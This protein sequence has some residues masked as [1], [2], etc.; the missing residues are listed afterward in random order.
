MPLDAYDFHVWKLDENVGS[1]SFACSGTVGTA[2]N[3]VT[4]SPVAGDMGPFN[5][6]LRHASG[7]A[8]R[9]TAAGTAENPST[10]ALSV[11]G[12]YYPRAAQNGSP[13]YGRLITKWHSTTF[14][15]GY[16]AFS[17]VLNISG[18]A[19]YVQGH[20]GAANILDDAAASTISLTVGQWHH[21][22]A[23]FDSGA[24]KLYFNGDLVGSETA[25]AS[26]IDFNGSSGGY[27]SL[28]A[29][30]DTYPVGSQAD[31]R[32]C[33]GV[34]RSQDYFREVYRRSRGIFVTE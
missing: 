5:Q 16:D 11:H 6:A 13:N 2:L 14:A 24:I 10:T 21:I 32:V 30:A 29:N 27:W 1:T 26:T 34:V 18:T 23:T 20:F 8:V 9:T 19:C 12:W 25:G 3:V 31:W 7:T 17:I 28:G 15:T 33:S 4:G 22:A